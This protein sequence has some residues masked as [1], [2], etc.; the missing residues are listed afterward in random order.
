MAQTARASDKT[1]R[2]L[3][4]QADRQGWSVQGGGKRHYLLRCPNPCRCS[5]I[6]A[7]SGSN[8]HNLVRSVTRLRNHTCWKGPRPS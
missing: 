3:L 8:V 6:L 2:L 7:A 5:Q 4:K 1:L